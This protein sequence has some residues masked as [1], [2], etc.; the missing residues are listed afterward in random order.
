MRKFFYGLG[1]FTAFVIVAGGIG[2]FILSRNGNAL[3]TASKAY[4]EDSVVAIAA[5]W[6]VDELWKR[7]SPHLRTIARPEDIRGFF[8]AAKGA[9]GP[10]VAYQGS[11]GEALMSVI[12]THSQ[13]SAKYI[14]RGQFQKGNADF[15]VVLIKQGDSWMIEGFHINSSALMQ[16]MVGVKS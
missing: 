1:V 4:V 16:R 6:N 10:L 14:A 13:V 5:N 9:L 15:Q 12:N 7:A 3:D 8:D 11:E 2:L